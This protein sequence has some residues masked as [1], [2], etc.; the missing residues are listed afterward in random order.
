MKANPSFIFLLILIKGHHFE[1]LPSGFQK[2]DIRK[3]DF[4][5]CLSQAIQGAIGQLKQP[6]DDYGL[7]QME[8]FIAPDYV[9]CELGNE[10]NGIRQKYFNYKVSG[11]TK[12]VK[13]DAKLDFS[14]RTLTITLFYDKVTFNLDYQLVGRIIVLYVNNTTKATIT[15]I[16]P[17]FKIIYT[18]ETYKKNNEKYLKVVDTVFRMSAKKGMVHFRDL[19][20]NKRLNED[21]C[22]AIE[23]E[24][25]DGLEYWQNSSPKVFS[26]A[27]ETIFNNLLEKVPV[28]E[29]VDGLE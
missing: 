4:D 14:G 15:M 5:R 13:T 7:P 9:R 6:I 23:E 12:I 21:I 24:W 10:T 28:K 11:L 8:P 22:I 18:M 19:F 26:N 29:L 25:E 17:T 27:F 2:C 3:P 20:K 1:K 16:K